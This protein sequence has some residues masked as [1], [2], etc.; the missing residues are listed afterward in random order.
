[1][2]KKV[3]AFLLLLL[4][5]SLACGAIPRT[6]R[7][8]D[9]PPGS[10]GIP[11]ALSPTPAQTAALPNQH[12]PVERNIVYC[13]M[14]GVPLRADIYFPQAADAPTPLLIFIH[15]GGW[16]SGT[17]SGGM[18]FEGIPALSY[19]GY[20]LASIDYRL[21]PEYKMPA[22]IEDAKCAVRSFRAHAAEYGID[23][24][25]IGVMGASAGGHLAAILGTAGEAAGFEVGEYLAYSSRVQAVVD[26]AGPADL[27]TPFIS[28]SE[29]MAARIF[30]STDSGNPL[31]ASCSPVTWISSDDPPFL[32]LH[33]DRDETVPV[34]QS[35]ELYDRLVA[36]GVDARLIIVKN[37][38][39]GFDFPDQ[40]PTRQ[41]LLVSILGFLQDKLK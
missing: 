37:A 34:G 21:A 19:A 12:K 29:A 22:M 27:T 16:S 20:T 39:H 8:V 24:D 31:F 4:L 14:D 18:G 5:I 35:R 32:I 25:R 38:G 36:A 26:M 6:P 1:M 15:G 23:P 2:Q 30:G 41:E 3:V 9:H 17:K 11:A 33:G 13:I 7:P 28:D 10:P 40:S